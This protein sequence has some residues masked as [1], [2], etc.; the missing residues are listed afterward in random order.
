MKV[1]YKAADLERLSSINKT[2]LDV[3][4]VGVETDVITDFDNDFYRVVGGMVQRKTPAEIDSILAT[5]LQ[6]VA[7][8]LAAEAA[9]AQTVADAIASMRNLPGWATWTGA[10]AEAWI[11]TNVTDLSS[12]KTA[13]KAMAKAICYLRDHSRIVLD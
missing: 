5:R 13:L 10:Q 6:A 7:D 1:A 2:I 11:Q 4:E 9:K 8:A 12:A 3:D